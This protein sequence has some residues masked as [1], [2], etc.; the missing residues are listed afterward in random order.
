MTGSRFFGLL[1][2]SA[3]VSLVIGAVHS[4]PALAAES[5]H[6]SPTKGAIGDEINVSGSKYDPGDR[7]YVHFSSR[8]ASEG[9][10]INELVVWEEVGKV[11]AGEQG[12]TDEGDIETSF[13]V[14]GELNDGDETK[15]VHAGEYFIYTTYS[16]EGKIQ[17]IHEFTVTGIT[18]VY[19]ERSPV[20]TKVL[21]K[22]V[23]FHRDERI[24][25][26]YNDDEI[27]IA[28]GDNKTND[29]GDFA[30]SVVVPPSAAGNHTVTI[31]IDQDE[32][33][34][35]FT[36]EPKISVSD[37]SVMVGDKATVTGT[38]FGDETQ[39]V[40]TFLDKILEVVLADDEG[41]FAINFDVPSVG[42]G[43]YDIKAKDEHDNSAKAEFAITT[44]LIINPATSPA[45]PGHSGMEVTISGTGF[46]PN[47]EVTIIY[48]TSPVVVAI[49]KSSAVGSFSA[50]FKVPNS[51]FGEHTITASDGIRTVGTNFFMESTPPFPPLLLLPGMEAKPQQPVRFDWED[52]YDPSGVNYA[53][54]IA[55]DE[56]FSDIVLKKAGLTQS[57]YTL[58]QE[59]ELA[60]TQN[61][62]CYYWQVMAID[63]ASNSSDWASFRSFSVGPVFTLP[64]WVKYSLG[65]LG[66][67]VLFLIVLLIVRKRRKLA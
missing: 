18:L 22:G 31:E 47:A 17:A 42:P 26:F 36:V 1:V 38:G 3:L 58:T 6:I 32:A 45:S 62:E 49:T 27:V 23:G 57:E 59:E 46:T 44:D 60:S 51:E 34:A 8:K 16:K 35:E 11:I 33:T 54:Q 63:G 53:L 52:V 9:D 67:L 4:L 2:I 5:L 12:T 15:A 64:D 24:E 43:T 56:N 41:N 13:K 65:I 48:T 19:P 39:V 61:D 30:L 7:V 14:P 28:N 10:D 40:I 21:I 55:R 37:T 29:E 25:V 50:S 20:G 66:G